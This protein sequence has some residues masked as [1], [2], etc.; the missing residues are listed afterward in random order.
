MQYTV[1][2]LKRRGRVAAQ[3]V[4]SDINAAR[5]ALRLGVDRGFTKSYIHAVGAVDSRPAHRA[6]PAMPNPA[7]RLDMLE[8]AIDRRRVLMGFDPKY[9]PAYFPVKW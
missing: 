1:Y 7:D 5:A 3:A 6:R 8:L 2:F 9:F 4:Y